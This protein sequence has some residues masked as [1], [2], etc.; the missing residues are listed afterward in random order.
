MRIF[1]IYR[2]L[3]PQIFFMNKRI[4]LLLLVLT[5]AI[6][7]FPISAQVQRIFANLNWLGWSVG[8]N[9]GSEKE[10][11]T[12][13][14]DEDEDGFGD[15]NI[16]TTTST[17]T[18]PDG[19]VAD[20][21]DCN[22]QDNYIYPGKW[23]L[24]FDHD[25]YGTGQ[26]VEQCE[27]PTVPSGVHW[28]RA[29][30]LTALT[31]DCNDENE[32]VHP[33]GTEVCNGYDDNCNN[34]IDEDAG[35][36]E[37]FFFQDL[38]GDG[39]GNP[40]AII[41]VE[42]NVAPEGYVWEDSD[43]DDN[44]PAIHSGAAEICGNGIDDNCNGE[45]DEECDRDGDG[46]TEAQGD[47]DD[48][49]AAVHPSAVEICG[50]DI[51]ENCN[52]FLDESC[53]FYTW[54]EDADSDGFGNPENSV[55]TYENIAP[56]GYVAD[57]TDCNDQDDYI[58]P[59][60]WYLDFDQDGYGT[61][62]YV[63]QCERPMVPSGVHWKRANQLTALTGDCN[64]ENED[65][66]PGA[67]EICN[68][69]DNNC[70]DLI[71]EGCDEFV[72][73]RDYDGDGFGDPE[74]SITTSSDVPPDGYVADNTDCNDLDDYVYPGKWYID[75]DQDGYGTGYYVEQCERP[76]VPLGYHWERA[77]Y[78]IAL[79]GDCNDDN[80]E[81][82]P[83][84]DEICNGYDNNCNDLIDEGCGTEGDSDGDG[85]LNG[86]DCEPNDP[87]KWRSAEM[88]KDDDGDFYFVFVGEVCYGAEVPNGYT[89]ELDGF[90][91]DCDD[92]E[93]RLHGT[94]WYYIDHD[95]DG[96]GSSE[97]EQV[98]WFPSAAYP[99]DGYSAETGD[100]DDNDPNVYP[101]A[102]EICGNGKDDNCDDRIDEDCGTEGDSDGDGVPDGED[103][104]PNDATKWRTA[105]MF[106]DNDGDGYYVSVGEVC[107]GA[108]VP[109]GLELDG[110]ETNDCDD[111]DSYL[112]VSYPYYV[113]KD[114]DGIGSDQVEIICVHTRELVPLGYSEET[115]DCDDNDPNIQ[116]DCQPVDY[117]FSILKDINQGTPN[118]ISHQ[119]EIR[120]PLN[121]GDIAYFAA[122][123]G[124]H[125]FELWK[126][127]GTDFGTKMIK[128]IS[129]GETSSEIN[130]LVAMGGYAY[131]IVRSEENVGLWRSDGTEGGTYRVKELSISSDLQVAGNKLFFSTE[132]EVWTSDGT[133]AGTFVVKSIGNGGATPTKFVTL[134]NVVF[135]SLNDG[136]SG[137][138]LWKSD[139]TIA[140][141]VQVTNI[142][143]NLPGYTLSDITIV[144]GT[145]YFLASELEKGGGTLSLVSL[146]KSNGAVGNATKV[147]QLATSFDNVQFRNFISSGEKLYFSKLFNYYRGSYNK[148]ELWVSAGTSAS[149]KSIKQFVNSDN[150]TYVTLDF[151][152]DVDGTLFFY[153]G[154]GSNNE[155]WK[156][157]GT[158]VGTQMVK[159]IN[160]SGSSFVTNLSNVNGVLYFNAYDEQHGSEIWKSNGTE[161]GTVLVQDV[162]PGTE[163]SAYAEQFCCGGGPTYVIPFTLI[164]NKIFAA[165]KTP[166]FGVE[167]WVSNYNE[168]AVPTNRLYVNA[169]VA[170]SG[171]GSSWQC[172]VKELRTAITMVKNN[173][174]ITEIWVAKGTYKP[175]SGNDRNASFVLSRGNL[176]IIGGFNGTETEA[177]S[178]NPVTNVTTLSGDIG[179]A[180]NTSD[181]SYHI[182]RV[183]DIPA[184]AGQL[185][186]NGFVFEK[187]NADDPNITTSENAY[188]GAVIVGN[189]HASANIIV[190]RSAFN[191]NNAIS[192]AGAVGIY[193]ANNIEFDSCVFYAN[194][195][196]YGGGIASYSSSPIIKN[197]QFR[198]NI[199]NAGNG[200]AVE[201]YLG[202]ATFTNAFFDRNVASAEGGAVHQQEA[203]AR[204]IQCGFSQNSA[205]IGGAVFQQQGAAEFTNNTLFNN[206][207]SSYGGGVVVNG[208]GA[209]ILSRNSIYWKN[210]NNGTAPTGLGALDV[211]TS[212]GGFIS[213][214]YK[215]MLQTNGL[216]DADNGTNIT[217]NIRGV[218][219]QFVS[220]IK[221]AGNDD[222]FGYLSDG[223]QLKNTSPARNVGVNSYI[224]GI[225]QDIVGNTRIACGTV[226][227]GV[228]ENQS[229]PPSIQTTDPIVK[230]TAI[231]PFRNTLQIK[232][233]GNE[234]AEM[235]I[236]SLGGR[237]I[238]KVGAIQKG[239]TQLNTSNWPSGMYQIT[240]RSAT[241]KPIVLKVIKLN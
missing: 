179:V 3:T 115:G 135:F 151:L 60:K 43:C 94:A 17:D 53:T 157:D 109:E 4:T 203:S 79:T 30:E 144:D 198:Q 171:Y 85:V 58:Y 54:Y 194:T 172:A 82:H 23:Y 217:G 139:G 90:L 142:L 32:E 55:I 104:A 9:S 134:N 156:S 48:D 10:D 212:N 209:Y 61:G 20:N 78:M 211:V 120:T 108:E 231:N 68:G 228:Y 16:S 22:D 133:E 126:S 35:C 150:E 176:S 237:S 73:Y 175:T 75:F 189:N 80:E 190:K 129:S 131:F 205:S 86:E 163:S 118:G 124:A 173:L 24:D 158:T 177:L 132:D 240:I 12:W 8:L 169:S 56:T 186:I 40:H 153:A 184:A 99:P 183:Q 210:V 195:A 41:Y 95:R 123:D 7:Y 141:T 155:L 100:C 34:K 121:L 37:F 84:A 182:L 220:E 160:P 49:N 47:C 128:D 5:T 57:N 62:N 88:Y 161:A 113:D 67:D 197:T 236:S 101:G 238:L 117:P 213:G 174:S 125:G 166:Q 2:F 191:S 65:V 154:D 18:A 229:C 138:E 204:Y 216:A 45:I 66:H 152:T 180:N 222:W 227:L 207:S 193:Q 36:G 221:P 29:N 224:V 196:G 44:N 147:K 27:R 76:M 219:P 50:N 59:G 234:K 230:A 143:S 77:N 25:G 170:S 33:N 72:W 201:V 19:Y 83:G 106:R 21:T 89:L 103:C 225:D 111:N 218:D 149:T 165:R 91:G 97:M 64:D 87:T 52:N 181:N 96:I 98:C 199:A 185:T 114:G 146:W 46:Y 241:Q 38:D 148:A 119:L 167:F 145:L 164:G 15:P 63:E 200:G 107:Y 192:A 122:D 14:R 92:A 127:D 110:F 93:P 112:Y 178:A 74:N 202:I 208:A 70:N 6:F 226:D 232:Y 233:D 26:F 102:P 239:Q 130:S 71:D 187:G 105:E 137:S 188:G 206:A 223:L 31:G 69:Y 159:D 235:E 168:C 81:V 13:Y 215:N 162:V 51:D 11:Y 39:Y 42:L 1:F 214:F 140:G 136:I 116:Y 28:K